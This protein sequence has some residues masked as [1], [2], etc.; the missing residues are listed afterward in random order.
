MAATSRPNQPYR[1]NMAGTRHGI[2]SGHYLATQAGFQILEAGGNAID[3][4]IAAGLA[5][6][7]LESEYVG[8]AGVAPIMIYIAKTR[9][10][11]TIDG[12]GTWPKAAS[13]EYFR[14]QHGN[15]IPKGIQRTVTPG[16]MDAWITALSRHGTMSFGDVAEAAIRFADKGFPMYTAMTEILEGHKNEIASYPST[17]AVYL[18]NGKVP[19]PGE[20]FFQKDL[21]RSLKYMVAE[22]KA[23]MKKGLKAG[24]KA[25]RDAFYKGDIAQTFVKYHKANGGLL[26]EA[27]MAGYRATIDAPAKIKFA[28]VDLYGCGP[29]CQGPMLL[30]TL[31]ILGGMDL[32]G[33]GHNSIGY[34]HAVTEAIKLAAADRE[35]Y[36]GDPKFVDVPI[37]RLLSA[38]YASERRALIQPDRAGPD[39]PPPGNANGKAP[40]QPGGGPVGPR[41]G[42]RELDTSYVCC[43]DRHGNAISATP[44]DGQIGGPI[45]PGTGI[46]PS[47]RG[48]QSWVDPSHPSC[49]A[50]GKRPRLTPNPAIAIH[51]GKFVMPFGTPGHDTQTQVMSQVFMNMTVFG[52]SP[53][54]AIEAPRLAT[55]SFPSSA[56]PHES[57]PGLV[58]VE[59]GFNNGVVSGLKGF[60]HK[61]EVWPASGSDYQQALNG[62]CIVHHDVNSGVITAAA[63][64]R[65]VS[66]AMAW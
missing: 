53:Q 63:D 57:R 23:A 48:Y 40:R 51:E 61:A 30:Q 47:T 4:G 56:F 25:A 13:C 52:M 24:I 27:D 58:F 21:A 10:I 33:L 7:I 1:P 37:E 44:S 29:W 11:V 59:P 45:V 12:L 26:T 65:R 60:G 8:I 32:K 20:I 38:E 39:L 28:G 62:A 16:A 54:Q 14:T 64:P 17:A 41:P 3:A 46:L 50:P 49:V 18:P 9:E 6:C 55:L 2:S 19:Q 35:G 22:E 31:N 66:Y 36:Y 42:P 34:A 15:I 5:I 43:V